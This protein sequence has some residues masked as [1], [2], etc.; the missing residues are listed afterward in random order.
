MSSLYKTEDATSNDLAL[1]KIAESLRVA[2]GGDVDASMSAGRLRLAIG[3]K[4]AWINAHGELEG[5][6]NYSAV[7]EVMR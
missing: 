4:S 7:D 2:F 1:N 5:E 6:A 3:N